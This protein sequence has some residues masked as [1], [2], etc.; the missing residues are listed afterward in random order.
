MWAYATGTPQPI[1]EAR[2][3]MRLGALLP[4]PNLGS[5]WVV[6][7]RETV[8]TLAGRYTGCWLEYHEGNVNECRWLCPGIGPVRLDGLKSIVGSVE[9]LV[10]FRI[11]T[12]VDG[13]P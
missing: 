9:Q 11:R 4:F 12:T 2:L 13:L 6:V 5:N 7:R 8:E 10:E 3:P 1:P